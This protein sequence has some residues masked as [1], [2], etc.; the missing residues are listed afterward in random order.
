ML[1]KKYSLLVAIAAL[2]ITQDLVNTALISFI[3]W[4]MTVDEVIIKRK[5]K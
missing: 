5:G 3:Y 2:V 1:K 4:M